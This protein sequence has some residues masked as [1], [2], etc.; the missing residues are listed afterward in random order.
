MRRISTIAVVVL[1]ATG[2]AQASDRPQCTAAAERMFEFMIEDLPNAP[3]RETIEATIQAKG[4]DAVIREM[5]GG[6][7]D[8]QCAFLIVAP[9]STVKAMVRTATRRPVPA[10]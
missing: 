3:Q 4:R 10:D 6:F 5:A 2:Y 7:T 1:A 8:D 9:D